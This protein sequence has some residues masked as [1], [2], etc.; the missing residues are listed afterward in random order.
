VAKKSNENGPPKPPGSLRVRWV[1]VEVTGADSTIEEALRTV[2]RM[3]RPVIEVPSSVKRVAES[4]PSAKLES[5]SP[6][7]PTLFDEEESESEEVGSELDLEGSSEPNTPV[8]FT[9]KKRGTGEVRD[10]NAGL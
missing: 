3:R 4:A 8:N 7:Q 10:R 5:T 6:R 1:E 9:A 2:E